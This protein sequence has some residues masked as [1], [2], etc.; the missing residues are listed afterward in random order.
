MGD[1][2]LTRIRDQGH[3]LVIHFIVAV[4]IRFRSPFFGLQDRLVIDR[5]SLFL[6]VLDHPED[7]HL[8]DIGPVNPNEAGCARGQKEH[9][10]RSQEMLGPVGIQD[11]AGVGLGRDLEEIRVGSLP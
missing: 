4:R 10:P 8:R 5:P 2:G 3:G 9:I 1:R 7:L 6:P 11:G